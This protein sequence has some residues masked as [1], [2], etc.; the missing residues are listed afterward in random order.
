MFGDFLLG[1]VM[2]YDIGTITTIRMEIGIVILERT[3]LI[4]SEAANRIIINVL[5]TFCNIISYAT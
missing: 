1:R 3:I 4:S 2:W 5:L